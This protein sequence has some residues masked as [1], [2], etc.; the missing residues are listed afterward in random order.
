MDHPRTT[1]VVRLKAST[2]QKV[3]LL[4]EQTGRTVAAQLNKL[5]LEALSDRQVPLTDRD[6]LLDARTYSGADVLAM[7]SQDGQ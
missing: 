6:D 1:R 4:A 7:V 3:E 5:V 2:Y